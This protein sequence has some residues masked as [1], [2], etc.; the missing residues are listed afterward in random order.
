MQIYFCF[1]LPIFQKVKKNV[2][3]ECS[4][5]KFYRFLKNFQIHIFLM[6]VFV[7]FFI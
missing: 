2:F 3:S 5:K 7:E 1:F 6:F 4:V